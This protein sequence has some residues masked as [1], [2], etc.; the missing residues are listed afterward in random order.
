M[1]LVI[2]KWWH[3]IISE[4]RCGDDDYNCLVHPNDFDILIGSKVKSDIFL[5]KQTLTDYVIIE[6]LNLTIRVKNSCL[7]KIE[8]EGLFLDDKVEVVKNVTLS[9]NF[10]SGKIARVVYNYRHKKLNYY[11]VGAGNKKMPKR[12]MALDLRKVEQAVLY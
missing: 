4:Y 6:Q 3:Q 2:F 7:T 12:F 9:S 8:F 10:M 11:L 5:V 1:E